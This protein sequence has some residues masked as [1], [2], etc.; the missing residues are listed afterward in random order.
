M[1]ILTKVSSI[2]LL[3]LVLMVTLTGIA[4]MAA[5]PGEPDVSFADVTVASSATQADVAINLTGIGG[6]G[7]AGYTFVFGVPVGTLS[8]NTT[9]TPGG[10][11]ANTPANGCFFFSCTVTD[12]DDQATGLDLWQVDGTCAA[13]SLPA[14][15]GDQLAATITALRNGVADGTYV[16]DVLPSDGAGTYTQ[17]FD[18]DVVVY[19]IPD[20]GSIS[21]GSVTF[22]EPTAVELS[23]VATNNTAPAALALW[24]LIAGGAAVALGGGFAFWRRKR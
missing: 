14:A 10:E 24:P 3:Y 8:F 20:D 4:S 13:G 16:L 7:A 21:D 12:I 9:C 6:D 22:G 11:F 2:A 15:M 19:N 1:K 23:A 5:G 18:P 17:V